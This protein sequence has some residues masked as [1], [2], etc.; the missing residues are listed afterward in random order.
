MYATLS[1]EQIF[2]YKVNRIFLYTIVVNIYS[3]VL[4]PIYHY[5]SF[6]IVCHCGYPVNIPVQ[7]FKFR[8]VHLLHSFL[9]VI[10][11]TGQREEEDKCQ[12]YR[13]REGF[14][15]KH[16]VQKFYQFIGSEG[17]LDYKLH[18]PRCIVLLLLI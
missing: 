9:R 8:T 1:L 18:S 5:Y 12:R 16:S 6:I 14:S 4:S 17:K 11:G 10:G 15:E 13:I 7:A 2:L 3:F